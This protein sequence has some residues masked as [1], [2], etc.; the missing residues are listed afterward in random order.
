MKMIFWSNWWNEFGRGNR[1]TRRKPAPAPLCPPQNPTWRPSLEPR[2]AA[3]GSQRLISDS[4]LWTTLAFVYFTRVY[5]VSS[6]WSFSNSRKEQY[7]SGTE[8]MSAFRW[9][10]GEVRTQL[11][12]WDLIS[13][14]GFCTIHHCIRNCEGESYISCTIIHFVMGITKR[15][16]PWT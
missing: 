6:L 1:S 2:T 7:V 14:T 4:Q 9:K 10:D 13:I 5:W 15:F 11:G 12:P 8:F 16:C 3:V